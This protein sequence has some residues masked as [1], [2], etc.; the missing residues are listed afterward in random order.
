MRQAGYILSIYRENAFKLEP[1]DKPKSFQNLII[2]GMK[3]KSKLISTALDY[4][5]ASS[6]HGVSYVFNRS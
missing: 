5:E 1:D 3:G 4:A 2:E 6:V